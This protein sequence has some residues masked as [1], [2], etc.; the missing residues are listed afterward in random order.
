M[1]RPDNEY[2]H[3]NSDAP[4]LI[5]EPLDFSAAADR[6]ELTDAIKLCRQ[7]FR[8]SP[9][10]S[11]GTPLSQQE[12]HQRGQIIEKDRT[13]GPTSLVDSARA[14]VLSRP[15]KSAA[16]GAGRPQ[17]ISLLDFSLRS[18]HQT[19]QKEKIITSTNVSRKERYLSE[20]SVVAN[21]KRKINDAPPPSCNMTLVE[22]S[23]M[24]KVLQKRDK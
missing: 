2:S 21:K 5:R 4:F 8:S 13:T 17:Q 15:V 10:I 23:D 22:T 20:Q 11:R 16:F 1:N 7:I 24:K 19:D 14:L 3:Y 12:Q 6:K 9:I 18:H